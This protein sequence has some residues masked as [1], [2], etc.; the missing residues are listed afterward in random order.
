MPGKQILK[1]ICTSIPP[2]RAVVFYRLVKVF[3]TSEAVLLFL[4][5]SRI[6]L[7]SN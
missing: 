6:K 2:A 3:Y 5:E 4:N 7:I 1:P